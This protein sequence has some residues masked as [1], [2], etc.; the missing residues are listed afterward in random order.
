MGSQHAVTIGHGRLRFFSWIRDVAGVT[1]FVGFLR[2]VHPECGDQFGHAVEQQEQA[3]KDSHHRHA[4]RAEHQEGASQHCQDGQQEET[5]SASEEGDGR[6]EGNQLENSEQHQ[7]DTDDHDDEA[8]E[9]GRIQE[10]DQAQ[11]A[12]EDGI[13]S[14]KKRS[15]VLGRGQTDDQG[16]DSCRDDEARDDSDHGTGCICSDDHHQTDGD[17]YVCAD[18]ALLQRELLG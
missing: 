16:D 10:Q 11:N 1:D 2:L 6:R 17:G 3:C 9:P 13:G 18:A 8:R 7:D 15:L 5:P 12:I 14:C 4:E